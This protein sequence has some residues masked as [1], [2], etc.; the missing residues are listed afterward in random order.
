MLILGFYYYHF[1]HKSDSSPVPEPSSV[2]GWSQPIQ[3]TNS[4]KNTCK[5]YTFP[6]T[7]IKEKVYPGNPTLNYNIL[8][9]MKGSSDIPTCLLSN[10]IISRQAIR[11]CT[12]Q[13]NN[14]KGN[15]SFN[16]CIKN[17]GDKALVGDNEMIF[18]GNGCPAIPKCTGLQAMVSIPFYK[19]LPLLCMNPNG[20]S[21]FT[22]S[23]C[24]PADS[25]QQFIVERSTFSKSKNIPG[26]GQN[27]PLTKIKHVNSNLC[28]TVSKDKYSNI[29]DYK[30]YEGM[31]LSKN[32]SPNNPKNGHLLTLG[33]CDKGIKPGYEWVMIPSISYGG[34]SLSPPQL[35][36]IG[37]TDFKGES[38][39]A[40]SIDIIPW[41]TRLNIPC[42]YN[43]DQEH[44]IV[45]GVGSNVL[46]KEG[47]DNA[48]NFQYININTYETIIGKNIPL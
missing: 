4:D 20:T 40:R 39:P 48:Y 35:C 29:Y 47:S 45:S 17:N 46:D 9:D 19:G 6:T 41:I 16:Q 44:P 42:L 30:L 23:K 18:T 43:G 27:G 11:T 3:G 38:V 33:K 13:Y 26:A 15:T 37:D 36:Y 12:Q 2:L 25:N 8:Y 5:L 14:S 10:Q 31:D 34:S 32:P 28:M 24:N 22:S 21:H 7:V 1:R